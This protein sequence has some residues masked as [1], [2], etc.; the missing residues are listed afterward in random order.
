MRSAS[1]KLSAAA[2]S[3]PGPGLACIGNQLGG[4]FPCPR[5]GRGAVLTGLTPPPTLPPCALEAARDQV[6]AAYGVCPTGPADLPGAIGRAVLSTLLPAHRLRYS[7][8]KIK[9][10]T[11]RY[12]ARDDTRPHTTTAITTIGIT[13]WTPPLDLRRRRPRPPPKNKQPRPP[14]PPTRRQRVTALMSTEP[15]RDWSGRELAQRLQIT[16]RNLH[17]QLGEWAKL[18]FI[19]RTGFA[20]YTLKTPPADTTSTTGPG[21]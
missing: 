4:L 17:T 16:P 10:P 3:R 7:A 8:R 18:G 20:T 11:S 12:Q 9:A 5:P 6:T 13:I 2:V 21:P 1:R 15:H 14:R 19:T